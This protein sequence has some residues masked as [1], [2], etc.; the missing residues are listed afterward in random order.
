M[1]HRSQ[2]G[3][4]PGQTDSNNNRVGVG[5]KIQKL[6]VQINSGGPL[7]QYAARSPDAKQ[8]GGYNSGG[9]RPQPVLPQCYRNILSG[10]CRSGFF[11]RKIPFRTNQDQG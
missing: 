1:D 11:G 4:Y 6:A 7:T 10:Q 3:T 2:N 9:L 5:G 8:G